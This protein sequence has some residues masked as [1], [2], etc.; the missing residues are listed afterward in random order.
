M[1]YLFSRCESLIK[2]G[3]TVENVAQRY[4]TAI[5]YNAKELEE[6]CFRFSLNH[7]TAT[8]QTDA[9]LSLDE[10]TVKFFISK[11]AK[12]GAFKS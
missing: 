11:A 2:Q 3:I 4:A 8:T 1:I 5:K 9:F 6:F 12:H 7:M 10:A